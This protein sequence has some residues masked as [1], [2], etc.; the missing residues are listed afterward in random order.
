MKGWRL[1]AAAAAGAYATNAVP[2]LWYH[3]LLAKRTAPWL[4]GDGD[5]SGVALTFDDGPDPKSTPLVLD[6]LESAGAGATFF[7]LGSQVERYPWLA[8]E[9]AD[10]NF[11]IGLHGHWHRVHLLRSRASVDYDLARGTAAIEA[12]TGQTPTFFRPPYGCLTRAS[13]G[14]AHRLGLRTVLWGTWGRDWRR[15]STPVSV[16]ADLRH[17]LRPGSTILLHDSDCTSYPG[18]YRTT[19]EALPALF[20]TANS[21]KLAIRA[22]RDHGF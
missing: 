18:S 12:A 8:R 6:L 3:W 13:L 1:A 14:A 9:V 4:T 7:M 2:S 17:R 22:L 15:A 11:E 19:L 16:M 10:R 20:D 5:P 21:N